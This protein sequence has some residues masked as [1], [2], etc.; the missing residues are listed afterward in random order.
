MNRNIKTAAKLAALAGA[1]ALTGCAFVPD[2]VHPQYIPQANVQKIPGADKVAV[3]V[4]VKNEKKRHDQVSV[5]VSPI[6]IHWAGVY[7]HVTKDFKNAIDSALAERGF[8][9]GQSNGK[10]VTVT[11]NHFYYVPHPGFFAGSQTGQAKFY[12]SVKSEN[13]A[14]LYGK[15]IIINYHKNGIIKILPGE[16][17]HYASEAILNESV[18]NIVNNKSFLIALMQ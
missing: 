16:D 4:V 18:R 8:D 9:I 13:G 2:T 7:M 15:H 10:N 5:N 3:D 6:G 1:F 11:I 12:V 14:I 17:R